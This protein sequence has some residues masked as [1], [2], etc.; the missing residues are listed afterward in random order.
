MDFTVYDIAVCITF[1]ITYIVI[2]V[3]LGAIVYEYLRENEINKDISAFET[4]TIEFHENLRLTKICRKEIAMFFGLVWPI[5][6]VFF[7]SI[8]FGEGIYFNYIYNGNDEDR[9]ASWLF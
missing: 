9:I 7:L 4:Y 1:F 3:T 5:S 2:G 6:V 8:E